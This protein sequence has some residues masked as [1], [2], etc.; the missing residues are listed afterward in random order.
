M[1]SCCGGAVLV[2]VQPAKEPVE[3]GAGE[4]PVERRGRLLIAT[5]EGEQTVLDLGEV[6]EVVGVSTLRWITE[7]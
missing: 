7:K 6:G 3:V 1:V 5:L 4:A 2:L